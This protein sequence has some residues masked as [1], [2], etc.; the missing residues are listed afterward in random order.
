MDI[1]RKLVTIRQVRLTKSIEGADAIELAFVD[2]WQC[3]VKKGE[4]KVGDT[5]IYAEVD[6][7]LPIDPRFEFLRKSSFR[8]MGDIEG[9][10]LK[11]IKLRKQLSQGLLL[12]VTEFPEVAG[13]AIGDDVTELLK[14]V[15]WEPQIPACLAGNAKGGFPGFITRTDEE[16][17]QNLPEFFEQYFDVYFEESIKL[18]GTSGTFYFRDG[19]FG[20][21]SR[22]LELQ[23]SESNTYWRMAKELRLAER[24]Q[25]LGRN[26]ALQ[27][28][29]I[30][31]GI[32]DNNE[33]LMGQEF[34][35]FNVFDID[36]GRYLSF[37]ERSDLMLRMNNVPDMPEIKSVPVLGVI[38]VFQK[39][40]TMESL[41]LHA[42]GPS[43]NPLA[44]REGLVY[45]SELI[46]GRMIS[47]KVL[48]NAYLLGGK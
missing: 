12:P 11:S 17:I 8:K 4:F 47:F 18:D 10:R 42:D 46:D 7:F 33:K 34:R 14:V 24:L 20:V 25:S 43:M 39:Y 9:F 29:I 13:K 2:G 23:E 15:K 21:C 6:S 30:G 16:R 19:V 26:I 27:G 48:S 31:A 45:K 1:T 3:V 37:S 41:L 28:E 35:L 32:Q 40:P 36:K 22:N 5:A 44:I 38:Q